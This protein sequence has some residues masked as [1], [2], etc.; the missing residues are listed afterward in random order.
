MY[1]SLLLLSLLSLLSLLLVVLTYAALLGG[2]GARR[3]HPPR[4]A[5]PR[6][7]IYIYIYI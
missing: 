5:R 3:P 6:G 4:D 7:H 2:A 1:V